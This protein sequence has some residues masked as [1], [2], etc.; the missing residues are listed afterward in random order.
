MVLGQNCYLASMSTLQ[1]LV[2]NIH[3]AFQF[4]GQLLKYAVTFLLALMQPKAVLAARLLA[5]VSGQSLATV[6]GRGFVPADGPRI[7]IE[8]PRRDFSGGQVSNDGSG[9]TTATVSTWAV[10][11]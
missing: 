1:N 5:A 8:L 2:R 4:I 9:D 7:A 6:A 3:Q 11:T 10:H